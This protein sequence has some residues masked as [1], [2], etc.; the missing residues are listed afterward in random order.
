MPQ[1][2]FHFPPG[3]LWGTATAAH[4]VEGNNTNNDWFAWENTPGRIQEGGRSGLACDWWGGRWKEDLDRAAEASQNAHRFS[5]EWSR[6]QPA[7][8]R[9]DEDALDHY[10]QMARG[11][12]DRGLTP[13]VTLHHVTSPLW[14][15]EQGGWE[16]DDTPQKFAVFV[17]RVVDALKEYVSWWVT[18]NEPNIYAG[19]GYL[20]GNFPPG[21]TDPTAAFHVLYNLLRGHVLA[22]R[23]IHEI[24]NT[25]RAS[26]AYNYR[27]FYP[28]H[29]WSPPDRL[30]ASVANRAYNTAFPDALRPGQLNIFTRRVRVP[31]ALKTLDYFGLNFYT[32][33]NI[34]LG[35]GQDSTFFHRVLP[36]GV[37]AGDS[38]MTGNIPT[39]MYRSLKWARRFNV[40]I[41]ITEN[42]IED[43][44]DLIRPKYLIQHVHQL[45]RAIA[46]QSWPVK[47]YFFW[48]QV[49]N[50][51]WER[52]WTQRFGL[53]G[54]DPATQ[55]RTRRMS[56]LVYGEICQTNSIS[57][58]MVEKYVPTLMPV[59]FPG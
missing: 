27:P 53:W 4:Q 46:T 28:A 47:G 56:A 55:V 19:F 54:L 1:A 15:A 8:D 13:M 52:G 20:T 34:G 12:L 45:W 22:Y 24:Q 2:T 44:G 38:G 39:E 17:R 59:L 11:M 42:G 3:F 31:E 25:G 21:K 7:P 51:E 36:P 35:P 33:E 5:V 41:V 6:I 30:V 50:F 14:L 18:I 37:E 23:A 16:N 10:R 48:S 57:S 40:P 29:R 9:W 26:I 58:E 43:A 32:S 49:D